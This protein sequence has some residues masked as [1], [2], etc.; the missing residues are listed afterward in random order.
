MEASLL[1]RIDLLTLTINLGGDQGNIRELL[2]LFLLRNS[3]ALTEMEKAAAND[4]IIAWLQLAH[5]M[6]GAVNYIGAKRFTALCLEAEDIRSLPNQQSDA[7]LY[8]MRK[9]M[10]HLR[11]VI[12]QHLGTFN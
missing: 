6:K 10:A 1:Q 2:E 8:H 9:E 3:E 5:K 11:D 12:A 7:V 4:N